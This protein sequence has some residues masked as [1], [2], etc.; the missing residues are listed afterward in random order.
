MKN[1]LVKVRI[2]FQNYTW[3]DYIFKIV[4]LNIQKSE[5]GHYGHRVEVLIVVAQIRLLHLVHKAKSKM[6]IPSSTMI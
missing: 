3:K 2:R 5:L 1:Y 6:H 4:K